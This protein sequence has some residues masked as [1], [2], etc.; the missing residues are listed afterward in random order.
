MVNCMRG[1]FNCTFLG[2]P[3]VQNAL[4]PNGGSIRGNT[5]IITMCKMRTGSGIGCSGWG[6]IQRKSGLISGFCM[7]FLGD[8]VG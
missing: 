6:I 4:K 3:T 2:P 5:G 7:G 1:D 8:G